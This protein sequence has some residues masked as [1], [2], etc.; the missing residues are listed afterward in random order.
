MSLFSF[1][2]LK[3]NSINGWSKEMIY[4][5]EPMTGLWWLWV[6]AHIF[7]NP[8]NLKNKKQNKKNVGTTDQQMSLMVP[9]LNTFHLTVSEFAEIKTY[10][11]LKKETEMFSNYGFKVPPNEPVFMSHNVY[12]WVFV[13]VCVASHSLYI[14]WQ[15]RKHF[16]AS[17]SPFS[18]LCLLGPFVAQHSGIWDESG[19]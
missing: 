15:N 14:S 17:V 10:Y 4:H 11:S 6:I 8:F 2:L 18:F 12:F 3:V 5:M 7:K 16:I 9:P 19:P 13:Y 1:T